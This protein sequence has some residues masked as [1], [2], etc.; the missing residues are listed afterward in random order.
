MREPEDKN[1]DVQ[2]ERPIRAGCAIGNIRD[3]EASV[4]KNDRDGLLEL[5]E[6]VVE[7]GTLVVTHIDRLSRA[8]TY[9]L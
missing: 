7:E 9:G 1:L 6:L 5:M 3:K 2:V 4:A 8:L